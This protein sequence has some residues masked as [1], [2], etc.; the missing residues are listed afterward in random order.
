MLK[1]AQALRLFIFQNNHSVTEIAEIP[2]LNTFSNAIFFNGWTLLRYYLQLAALLIYGHSF[3]I[4]S[5]SLIFLRK[6]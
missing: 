4:E 5:N 3:S 6:C 2:L 1:E